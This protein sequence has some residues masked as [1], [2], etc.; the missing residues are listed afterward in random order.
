MLKGE[1]HANQ[2]E[3]YPNLRK[4]VAD[5]KTCSG[6]LANRHNLREANFKL[7]YTYNPVWICH[8]LGLLKRKKAN[9]KFAHALNELFCFQF[10]NLTCE[11]T[12]E[13]D[14]KMIL[15]TNYLGLQNHSKIVITVEL[16]SGHRKRRVTVSH[17][18]NHC[19]QLFTCLV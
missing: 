1:R 9:F 7:A 11:V 15:T 12:G 16:V 3:I 8:L 5:A 14:R 10:L 18:I 4:Y 2:G 6:K 13:H 17:L 19:T